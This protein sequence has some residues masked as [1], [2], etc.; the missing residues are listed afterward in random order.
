MV[1]FEV[2]SVCSQAHGGMK[3]MFRILNGYVCHYY[4]L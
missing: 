4:V 2:Y 3:E 1:C